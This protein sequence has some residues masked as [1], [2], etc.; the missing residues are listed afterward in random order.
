MACSMRMMSAAEAKT[1]HFRGQMKPREGSRLRAIYDRLQENRGSF[2]SL[3]DLIDYRY[4]SNRVWRVMLE[5]TYG[6][7]IR[8]HS[9]GKGRGSGRG[10]RTITYALV[11]E[12]FG[13]CYVD[14]VAERFREPKVN[15]EPLTSVAI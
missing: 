2:V 15:V 13:D 1:G 3:M 9:V 10:G 6:L 8:S 5:N 11:G 12:W 7:D 14:Y 4:Q